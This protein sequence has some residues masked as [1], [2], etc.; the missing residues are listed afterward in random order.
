MKRFLTG[1]GLICVLF[2]AAPAAA[3]HLELGIAAGPT[4]MHDES[5]EAFSSDTMTLGTYGLDIR[6]ELGSVKGVEFVLFVGYRFGMNQGTI[7]HMLDT[8]LYSHDFRLG[9]RVRKDLISWLGIFVEA[10]GGVLLGF[11]NASLSGAWNGNTTLGTQDTYEDMAATWTA[12]GRLGVETHFSRP[13]LASH[14]IK[15]FCF[16]G[17]ISVGYDAHGDLDFDP[18]L[19][20]G[21]DNAIDTET[22]GSWGGLNP[23]GITLQ[24]AGSFYFF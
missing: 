13:W 23:S 14:N 17:E 11:M 22:L 2:V 19:S 10:H 21:G 24:I 9:L 3:E 20:G 8:E 7:D 1:M 16:G 4:F 12:G 15:R 6:S 18:T 5:Y